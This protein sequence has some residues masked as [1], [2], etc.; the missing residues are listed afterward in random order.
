MEKLSENCKDCEEMKCQN[1]IA[2]CRKKIIA[3]PG[4]DPIRFSLSIKNIKEL[5]TI[6]QPMWNRARSC[7]RFSSMLD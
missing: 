5:D 1:G 6:Y 2:W 3:Y 4:G 7:N